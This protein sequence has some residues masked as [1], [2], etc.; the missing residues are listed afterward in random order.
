MTAV[1]PI[2]RKQNR[3]SLLSLW[4]KLLV[5]VLLIRIKR[6]NIPALLMTGFTPM[7]R[8]INYYLFEDAPEDWYVVIKIFIFS[9]K[10]HIVLQIEFKKDLLKIFIVEKMCVLQIGLGLNLIFWRFFFSATLNFYFSTK[11]K[12]ILYGKISLIHWLRNS[13]TGKV[14]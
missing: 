9:K 2:S 8:L 12:K 5:L 10:K 4:N 1:Q 7:V 14:L 3:V 6:R 11:L 13:L